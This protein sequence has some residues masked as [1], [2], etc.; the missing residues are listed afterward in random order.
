M[1]RIT[2]VYGIRPHS[3][4]TLTAGSTFFT[5]RKQA[6]GSIGATK[7]MNIFPRNIHTAFIT[8]GNDGK[9]RKPPAAVM[10]LQLEALLSYYIILFPRFM[11]FAGIFK[12]MLVAYA[13][14]RLKV[15]LQI[16]FNGFAGIA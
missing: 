5:L 15:T 4:Q 9:I 13:P 12:F 8:D 16:S 1:K 14:R 10:V 11:V 7:N 2:K 6:A 3:Q